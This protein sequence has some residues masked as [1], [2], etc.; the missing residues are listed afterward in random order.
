MPIPEKRQDLKNIGKTQGEKETEASL[1]GHGPERV[2]K[3]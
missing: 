3:L 2:V 1:G